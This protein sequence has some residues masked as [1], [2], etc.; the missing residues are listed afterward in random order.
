MPSRAKPPRQVVMHLSAP[1]A[2][3]TGNNESAALTGIKVIIQNNHTIG[4][5]STLV[6]LFASSG[7]TEN[8]QSDSR[9]ASYMFDGGM[10]PN[11]P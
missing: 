11:I 4:V 7:L 2:A 3:P 1:A 5:I 6:V 8:Q 10:L 9:Y